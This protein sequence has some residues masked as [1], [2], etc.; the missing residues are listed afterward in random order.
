M[1]IPSPTKL[2]LV[3]CCP[4]INMNYGHITYPTTTTYLVLSEQFSVFTKAEPFKEPI[5][6]VNIFI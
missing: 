6:I 4:G 5:K 1:F 3:K 2:D